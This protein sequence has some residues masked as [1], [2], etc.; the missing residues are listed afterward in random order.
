MIIEYKP[1]G[2]SIKFKGR[3]IKLNPKQEEMAVSWVKKLGTPYVEDRVFAKNFFKDFKK[4]LGIKEKVTA[5]DFDFSEI[6]KYVESER[7][8][9]ANMPKEEKKKLA[10]ETKVKREANK[11]KYGYAMV[12]GEKIEIANY[13][14]EPSS[15]FMGRG[16]HPLRGSWKQGPKK[17]DIIL[18]LSID[19][20]KP[21]GNWKEIIWQPDF[22]WIASWYDILSGKKKYV[23]FSDEAPMKQKK[24]IRKF[25]RAN[26]LEEKFEEVKNYI[27]KNLE[28][29]DLKTRKVATVCYLIDAV[30]MRVGD[31]KD[32][33]EADTVGATTLTKD[34]IKILSKDVVKFDFLGKDS[35]RWEKEVQVPESVVNNLKEFVGEKSDLIFVGIRSEHVNEFLG[36]VM[37]GLTSKVFRTF[38]AT[39]AVRDFLKETKIKRD[40]SEFYKKYMAKLANIESAKVC[41]HKRTLPKS[42]EGPLQRKIERLKKAKK[43]AKENMKKYKQKIKD[44][45]KKYEERLSKYESK[46]ETY[47]GELKALKVK[48]ETKSIKKRIS[49]KR[50]AIRKQ[51]EMINK[52]KIKNVEQMEKSK[53]RMKQRKERD[54]L[55][56]EKQKLQIEEQKKSKDYNLNTSLKSYIDPRVYHKWAKKVDYDWKK[57]Y[58]KSLQKKFSWLEEK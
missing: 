43:K 49:S 29:N 47:S 7:E 52:L 15:I 38:S 14:A 36:Q 17:E 18:N 13:T 2:F 6:I 25:D 56:I 4:V 21:E 1:I 16:K 42:W 37:E 34:N 26:E 23:W 20:K 11:E 10:A 31:E 28:S 33:D 27:M 53:E 39:R 24:E 3:V 22:M 9:K 30:C 5:G 12:D 44:T 50:K 46:L 40:D 51:K 48:E 57:Y 35:V 58:S 19:S 41:N 54:R 45:E 55:S 32:E 8:K